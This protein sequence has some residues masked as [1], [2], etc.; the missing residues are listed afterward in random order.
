MQEKYQ[1]TLDLDLKALIQ[2]VTDGGCTDPG[3]ADYPFGHIAEEFEVGPEARKN[4]V[5]D[6]TPNQ[7]LSGLALRNS[8]QRYRTIAECYLPDVYLTHLVTLDDPTKVKLYFRLNFPQKSASNKTIYFI[9]IDKT[10]RMSTLVADMLEG[11]SSLAELI[12]KQKA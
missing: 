8:Y 5:I 1:A 10:W 6:I 4:G 11:R 9:T 2:F 3:A 7:N 12:R